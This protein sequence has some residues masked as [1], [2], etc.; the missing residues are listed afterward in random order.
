MTGKADRANAL[1]E[2]PAF[3]EALVNVRQALLARFIETPV[4]DPERLIQTRMYL[5]LLD[6]VEANLMQAIEDGKLEDFLI[7]QEK[8]DG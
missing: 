7:E 3:K 6:S 5:E 2:D 4:N 1:L 8:E